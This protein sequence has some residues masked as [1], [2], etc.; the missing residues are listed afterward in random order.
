MSRMMRGLR[1]MTSYLFWA[2]IKMVWPMVLFLLALFMGLA[3]GCTQSNDP[4]PDSLLPLDDPMSERPPADDP[5]QGDRENEYPLAVEAGI[6]A[7]SRDLGVARAE[8]EVLS[9]SQTEWSDGCLGLAEDD[10][11]CTQA[12][13]PGWQIF[14]LVEGIQEYEVRT[15]EDGRTVRWRRL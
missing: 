3:V 2:T 10:E 9:Q 8:I 11:F 15:S 1:T 7:L 13:V 4:L 12:I 14:V 6:D 5:A